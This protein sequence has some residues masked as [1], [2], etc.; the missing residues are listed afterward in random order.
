MYES[1]E[2]HDGSQTVA[3]HGGLALEG[4]SEL[5]EVDAAFSTFHLKDLIGLPGG[6]LSPGRVI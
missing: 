1:V 4:A 5:F 6:A 3:G 2:S